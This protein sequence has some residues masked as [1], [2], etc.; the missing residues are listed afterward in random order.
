MAI[1]INVRSRA[2]IES[3]IE[4]LYERLGKKVRVCISE[5]YDGIEGMEIEEVELSDGERVDLGV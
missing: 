4:R 3:I 5:G 2:D 1:K